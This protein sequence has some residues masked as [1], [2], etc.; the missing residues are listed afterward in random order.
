M[1]LPIDPAPTSAGQASK[2][3]EGDGGAAGT[4]W[5]RLLPFQLGHGQRQV[6]SQVSGAWERPFSSRNPSGATDS[7]W[8]VSQSPGKVCFQ[9]RRWLSRPVLP[10]D[11]PSLYRGAPQAGPSAASPGPMRGSQVGLRPWLR[12]VASGGFS[13]PRLLGTES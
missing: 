5:K 2:G 13:P 8:N 11:F 12:T 9:T 7:G 1:V 4:P 3:E 10:P 6:L